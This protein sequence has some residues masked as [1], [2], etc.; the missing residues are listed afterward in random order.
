MTDLMISES[1]REVQELKV[2]SRAIT[3]FPRTVMLF[4]TSVINFLIQSIDASTFSPF[5]FHLPLYATIG[6]VLTAVASICCFKQSSRSFPSWICNRSKEILELIQEYNEAVRGFMGLL[7]AQGLLHGDNPEVVSD[8]KRQQDFLK[9]RKLRLERILAFLDAMRGYRDVRLDRCETV[10]PPTTFGIRELRQ[11]FEELLLACQVKCE[12]VNIL[13]NSEE[14]FP[15]IAKSDVADLKRGIRRERLLL[16]G[17]T[18]LPLDEEE[19]AVDA[20]A[21]RKE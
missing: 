12:E 17:Q 4:I 8:L 9:L 11:S 13:I 14:R 1:R 6:S 3:W 5:S 20:V 21:E 16:R 10:L 7:Q 19:A 15:E 2:Q 18:L